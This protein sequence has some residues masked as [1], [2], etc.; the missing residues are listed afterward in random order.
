MKR[1]YALASLAMGIGWAFFP[2]CAIYQLVETDF[3][4]SNGYL[5]ASSLA[6][7]SVFFFWF[8]YCKE[9]DYTKD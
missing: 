6:M 2:V 3:E 4:T 1:I 7:F 5:G 8:K 9:K